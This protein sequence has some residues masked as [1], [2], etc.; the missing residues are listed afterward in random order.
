MS[1]GRERRRLRPFGAPDPVRPEEK[2]RDFGRS[3]K[4]LAGRLRPE[5]RLIAVAVILTILR[6]ACSVSA[7]LILARAMNLIFEGA[8]SRGLPAGIT[9]QQVIATLHA[10]GEN[11]LASMLSGMNLHPGRGV[12]FAAE[13]W[14]N[15]VPG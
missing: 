10:S 8:V 12:D 5:S 7:P 9:K 13:V 11:K 1:A 14:L 4:R 2:A 6:V 3:L 15:G